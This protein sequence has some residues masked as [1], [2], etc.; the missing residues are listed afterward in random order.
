MVV[1]YTLPVEI[2]E[3][4]VP[5]TFREAKLSYEFEL[6]R[7]AMVEEIESLHVNETW[8]LAELPK[9]KKAIG[10]KW[11]YAKKEESW[12]DSV[13]YKTRLVAKSYAQRESID[14]NEVFSSVVK[15]SSIFILLALGA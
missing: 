8:E 3:E 4:N 9:E 1:A 12:D 11:V 10:Y 6:W 15:Y 14:Y 5:C 13:R 2:V 7:K